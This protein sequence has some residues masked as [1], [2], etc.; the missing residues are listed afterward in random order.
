MITTNDKKSFRL[1]ILVN[2]LVSLV[3]NFLWTLFLYSGGF[4]K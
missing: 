1:V 2:V 3:V 4:F